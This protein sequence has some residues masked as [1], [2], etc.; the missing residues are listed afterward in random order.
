[1]RLLEVGFLMIK[2]FCFKESFLNI[3]FREFFI[4]LR[5][6]VRVVLNELFLFVVFLMEIMVFKFFIMCF[7]LFDI[8]LMFNSYC[9]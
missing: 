7:I 4:G 1:M 8:F 6:F 9:L 3:E 2:M 5:L